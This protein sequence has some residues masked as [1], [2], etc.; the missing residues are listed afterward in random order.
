[1]RTFRIATVVVAAVA[2]AALAAAGAL[3]GPAVKK[4]TFSASYAGT[5]VVKVTDNVAD[6]AVNGA[7]KGLPIGAGK[8]TGTGKGDSAQQP[9]VP[10]TGTGV[11]TGAA[12]TKVTFKI[13]AGSSG[14]GDE[15]GEVFSVNARATVVKATG[16]LAKAKGSLKITGVYDRNAGRFSVK[17]KG[18]LTQ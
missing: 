4:V 1:V 8:V 11:L 12:G 5:A 9:C 3:A 15:A 7:G 10:F 13:A 18:V 16:K 2:V 17:F 6:I 14:C